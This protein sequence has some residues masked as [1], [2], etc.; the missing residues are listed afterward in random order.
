M[1]YFQKFQFGIVSNVQ[2]HLHITYT[3]TELRQLINTLLLRLLFRDIQAL[4]RGFVFYIVSA[5]TP[6][7][8]YT[9]H[10]DC[11]RALE[12]PFGSRETPLHT[13]VRRTFF[14]DGHPYMC[15]LYVAY[16]PSWQQIPHI[17][18][19]RFYHIA[20]LQRKSS[21]MDKHGGVIFSFLLDSDV[22]QVKGTCFLFAR[23]V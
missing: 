20:T 16:L 8:N 6:V 21:T 11:G 3:D 22:K 5:M 19:A 13:S 7:S 12:I 9:I 10:L 14:N 2:L 23:H 17:D 18:A 15:G 4:A 1:C